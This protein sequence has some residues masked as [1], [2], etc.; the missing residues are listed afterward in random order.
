MDIRTHLKTLSFAHLKSLAKV[1]NLHFHISMKSKS[2][3][4]EALSRLYEFRN[5]IYNAKPFQAS[6]KDGKAKQHVTIKKTKTHD[7]E[8]SLDDWANNLLAPKKKEVKKSIEKPIEKPKEVEKP[9]LLTYNELTKEQKQQADKLTKQRDVR[10]KENEQMQKEMLG[11][12]KKIQEQPK[13]EN[14]ATN[15]ALQILINMGLIND[16]ELQKMGIEKPIEKPTKTIKFSYNKKIVDDDQFT[17]KE[18]Q[19]MEQGQNAWDFYKTP[20]EIINKIAEDI[21]KYNRNNEINILEP[22]AGLGSLITGIINNQDKLNI[23]LLDANEMN[24]DMYKL[25]KENFT[26]SN[27][28]NENFLKWNPTNKYDIVV[29][30]PPYEGYINEDIG[31]IKVAYL[32]H[33][34]KA[35]LILN[36][37]KTIYAVLPSLK[38]FMYDTDFKQFEFEDILPK[39]V[40][41][42]IKSFFNIKEIPRVICEPLLEKVTGWKQVK[43]SR[44]KLSLQKAGLTLNLYKLTIF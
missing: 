27:I 42:G 19:I 6:L 12:L 26:I 37:Q 40:I 33:V 7:W 25:L 41:K 10:K 31:R 16:K 24:D 35:I 28:Y 17:Q 14:N 11:D 43:F 1:T 15:K 5:G 18:L 39:T 44:G 23:N 3:V 20:T 13:M 9:K 4:I 2:T 21:V 32:Y 30:N 29:M 8:K 36:K 34:M 22:S 38:N